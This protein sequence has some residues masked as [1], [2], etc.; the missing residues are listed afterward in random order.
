MSQWLEYPVVWFAVFPLIGY[1]SG[2]IP[3]GLLVG[4]L[5][6]VDIREYGSGNIGATNAGRVLGRPW[7]FLCF[8]LDVMKGFGPVFMV[9]VAT[10]V[11]GDGAP[12]LMY[13]ASWLAV[14]FACILGHMF[15]VWLKFRGGKG[16]ATGL[17]VVC[18]FWPYLTLAGVAAFGVWIAITLI[19]RYVS[20]A[21]IVAAIMFPIFC[22]GINWMRL[23]SLGELVQLWPMGVFALALP[24][25]IVYSHR[26]NIGRLLA[27]TENKIG[28]SKTD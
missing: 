3:F 26:S 9:G 28:R 12:A 11:I 16:V 20:L 25:L 17:G 6:G 13:Q 23:G 18:G 14:T 22:V 10:R 1:L 2:S 15:P 4:R 8:G 5:R 27:G 21:S 7:G 19:T 24:T